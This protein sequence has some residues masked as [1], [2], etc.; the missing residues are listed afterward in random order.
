MPPGPTSGATGGGQPIEQPGLKPPPTGPTEAGTGGPQPPQQG[1]WCYSEKTKNYY[2]IPYGPCPPP[3][4][5][6]PTGTTTAGEP[7]RVPWQGL[8]PPEGK[9]PMGPKPPMGGASGP[10]NPPCH[11]KPGTNICHCG[12]S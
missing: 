11:I 6:P 8:V 7:P 12:G 9:P 4:M 2:M 1:I 10:C 3:W 5:K